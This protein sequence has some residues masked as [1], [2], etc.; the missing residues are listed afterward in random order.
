MN[1]P[2]LYPVSVQSDVDLGFV[3]VLGPSVEPNPEHDTDSQDAS[4]NAT[5]EPSS[6]KRRIVRACDQCRPGHNKCSGYRPCQTCMNIPSY[7]SPSK[8]FLSVFDAYG[9]PCPG[10]AK[11]RKCTYNLPARGREIPR[12]PPPPPEEGREARNV[13]APRL[14]ADGNVIDYSKWKYWTRRVCEAC[15]D[16]GAIC[17]GLVPCA[18]CFASRTECIYPE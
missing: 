11:K 3:H 4:D 2:Q 15:R 13:V 7:S 14:D 18:N 8:S 10:T 1:F 9:R 17:T 6:K 5:P 16:A 12:P